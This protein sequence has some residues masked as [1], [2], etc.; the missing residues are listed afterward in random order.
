M[1]TIKDKNTFVV[2]QQY[3]PAATNLTSGNIFVNKAKQRVVKE[4]DGALKVIA[5]GKKEM[6]DM[7]ASS[8]E[9][10]EVVKLVAAGANA[11]A[12]TVKGYDYLGQRM[13]ET[14]TLNGA[15]A[16]AGKKA[17]KFITDMSL[18]AGSANDISVKP[19]NVFGFQFNAVGKDFITKNGVVDTTITVDVTKGAQ[20]ATSKDPR[21][22]IDLATAAVGDVVDVVYNVSD[23]VDAD[24]KGGMLGVPHF[25]D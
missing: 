6:T 21:G 13:V 19:S 10:G 7:L 18:A 20:T 9:F 15:T 5:T 4:A 23:F 22:V 16:V 17:F 24:G 3:V 2:R 8:A 1:F 11:V 25:A 12:V 14:I